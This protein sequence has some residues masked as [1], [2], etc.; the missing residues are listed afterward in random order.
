LT[1]HCYTYATQTTVVAP[2]F[3][4]VVDSVRIDDELRYRP[5]LGDRWPPRASTVAFAAAAV[6]IVFLLILDLRRRRRRQS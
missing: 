1:L 3:D 6:S 5:R 4:R 2:I